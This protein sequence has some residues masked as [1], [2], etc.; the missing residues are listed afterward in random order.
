MKER[1]SK[2]NIFLSIEKEEAWLERM[3]RQGY[4]LSKAPG[5]LYTFE[6]GEPQERVYKIDF[7]FFKNDEE[8]HEYLTL[9][10]D[11]GWQA[12]DPRRNRGNFYFTALKQAERDQ[13]IFSDEV[14]KA[15]RSYRYASYTFTTFMAVLLP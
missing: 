5:L 7:R 2:F 1:T 8:M 14:S 6:K 13:H 3:S 15:Q 11:C 12:I 9:F 4:H 10:E